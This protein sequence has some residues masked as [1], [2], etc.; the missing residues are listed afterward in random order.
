MEY[1]EL[2]IIHIGLD[3]EGGADPVSGPAARRPK[4][5]APSEVADSG[6]LQGAGEEGQ[7][8]GQGDQKWSPP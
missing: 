8:E 3:K 1:I 2:S 5:P 4:D 7:E 6:G